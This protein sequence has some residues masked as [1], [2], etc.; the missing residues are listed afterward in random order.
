VPGSTEFVIENEP[1]ESK[2]FELSSVHLPGE[3]RSVDDQR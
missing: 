2:V 3:A 1:F